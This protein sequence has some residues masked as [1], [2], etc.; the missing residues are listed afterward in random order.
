[1]SPKVVVSS[2]MGRTDEVVQPLRDA[3]C[4]VVQTPPPPAVGMQVFTDQQK[5]ELFSDADAFVAGLRDQYSRDVLEACASLKIG[6]SPVIGT[7]QIDVE[8]ATGPRVGVCY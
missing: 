5:E 4:T 6:C 7:G 2:G 8:D 1:M 3:G